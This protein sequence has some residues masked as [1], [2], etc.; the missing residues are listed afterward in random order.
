MT[1]T[2]DGAAANAFLDGA[3]TPVLSTAV[4]T[5]DSSFDANREHM[6]RLVAGL[7]DALATRAPRR[8]RRQ[9]SSATASAASSPPASA[10][11]AWSTPA[12]PSSRLSPLAAWEMYGGDA[13]SAGIVTGVGRV[14]GRE[15]VIVANDATVKGGTYYPMTVKKHLR[16]QEVAEQNHLPCIYLVDSGGAFLPHAGRRLPGPRALRAH[17]LQPGAH[18]GEGHPAD[19][20]RHGLVHGRRRLRPGDE[21]RDRHRRGHRHDLP[22]RPA[23]REGRDRRGGLRRGPRRRGGPHRA[24]PAS[25]TTS[26]T[27][28]EDALAIVRSIVANLGRDTARPALGARPTPEPPRLRP[29]GHLRHR[30]DRPPPLLRRARG[31]R[32]PR[33]R[34][35]LPRVQGDLRLDARLRLRAPHGLPGRHRRQ[36]RHPLLRERAQGRALHR[37]LR[38][39]ARSRSSSCRTS[40]ASWSARSTSTRAS[41][42][43]ARRWSPP[44]PRAEVPKFTVIIGG[45]FGAGNYAMCGRAYSPRFLWIWPNA[46]IR[47]MGGQQA[48]NVLLTVRLDNLRADGH[49]MTRDEQDE[50]LRPDPRE[51]RARGQRLLQHRPPLG[52][53]HHRPARHPHLPRARPQRRDERADPGHKVRRLP[54]VAMPESAYPLSKSV[55]RSIRSNATPSS[56]RQ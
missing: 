52:R 45:S 48:A 10:S 54:D 8:R 53:R 31:H 27:S 46:Q 15:C 42:S 38:V 26:P 51:V 43:T 50:F 22:R 40:P 1:L 37:D 28:D 11:T 32:P 21:R 44:S 18:V 41:P 5:A 3:S 14:A 16:A 55:D 13:P 25:P 7:Q 33:R 34:Q 24:S 49:D 9:L 23:A 35:P 20:R 4:N 17:L 2:A 29:G 30:P 39:A 6:T 12:P 19:R 56:E 47:V 36:Q